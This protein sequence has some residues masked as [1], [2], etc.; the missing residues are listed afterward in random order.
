MGRVSDSTSKPASWILGVEWLEVLI[1]QGVGRCPK[2]RPRFSTQVVHIFKID[3]YLFTFAFTL[4]DNEQFYVRFHICACSVA[5]GSSLFTKNQHGNILIIL[6]LLVNTFPG[7]L[8]WSQTSSPNS[9]VGRNVV[10]KPVWSLTPWRLAWFK[11]TWNL[12]R[13]RLSSAWFP[14]GP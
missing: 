11:P 2:G 5:N 7:F 3:Y 12:P 9:E 6:P 8:F 1:Q 10:E 4:L 13:E 14:F